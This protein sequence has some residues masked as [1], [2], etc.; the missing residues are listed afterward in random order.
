MKIFELI[1]NPGTTL[2][3]AAN[4]RTI[5]RRDSGMSWDTQPSHEMSS[6][7]TRGR[8]D[9]VRTFAGARTEALGLA[10][11]P[12]TVDLPIYKQVSVPSSAHERS[13]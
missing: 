1:G 3:C 5:A 2:S 11:V 4:S 13:P 12:V 7:A 8:I 9:L 10:F 6:C